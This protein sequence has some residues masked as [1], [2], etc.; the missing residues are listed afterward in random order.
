MRLFLLLCLV[1]TSSL[2]Q[3]T[4][5]NDVEIVN[6]EFIIAMGISGLFAIVIATYALYTKYLRW[7]KTRPPKTPKTPKTPL[8]KVESSA[9]M[10]VVEITNTVVE[11][12]QI[13]DAEIECIDI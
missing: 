10:S 7:K 1:V 11:N 2:S 3:S 4:P 12:V 6:I 5:I 13:S 8:D 9:E